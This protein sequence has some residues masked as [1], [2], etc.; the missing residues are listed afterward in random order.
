MLLSAPFQ[1]LPCERGF[2][3]RSPLTNRIHEGMKESKGATAFVANLQQAIQV[4]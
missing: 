4:I 1:L 3:C 2:Y